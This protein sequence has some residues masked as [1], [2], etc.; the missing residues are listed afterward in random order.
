MAFPTDF[1]VPDIEDSV[2]LAEKS[3]A[4][5][6]VSSMI[7]VIVSTGKQVLVR[8]NAL[9]TGLLKDDI[10][11]VVRPGLFGVNVGKVDTAWHAREVDKIL[12]DVE[13]SMGIEI[14]STKFVPYLESALAVINAYSICMA[15]T[16]I[17][18]VA[19]GAEDFT[20]DMGT[21]RTDT[22]NEVFIP[23][24]MVAIAAQA[25]DV[26]PIDIVY[27]NFR[28]TQGLERDIQLG[29]DLGYKAKLAIHPSQLDPINQIYSPSVEELDYAKKVIAASEEAEKMGRG[30]TSIDGT[31][32]DAP[33]VKRARQILD[34]HISMSGSE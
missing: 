31:M 17:V 23:R 7:P 11:A 16:R 4:R 32:I 19:F 10:T 8:V 34:V 15:S 3:L 12:S 21:Q 22:G 28:D 1:L 25:A 2:P 9:D 14:G 13:Y 18:A 20:V 30:A 24:G 26:V 27:A 5:E 6:I 29:K 33:V